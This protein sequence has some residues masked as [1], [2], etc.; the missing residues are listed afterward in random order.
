MKQ[1]EQIQTVPTSTPHQES[2]GTVAPVRKRRSRRR[3][4]GW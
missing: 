3:L 1:T 4:S 2:N